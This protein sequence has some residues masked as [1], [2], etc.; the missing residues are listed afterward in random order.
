MYFAGVRPCCAPS[1][2]VIWRRTQG[3]L[4]SKWHQ[5]IIGDVFVGLC[6]HR[7]ARDTSPLLEQIIIVRLKSNSG[8]CYFPDLDWKKL[9]Q[10]CSQ[11]LAGFD[12]GIRLCGWCS[13][14]MGSVGYGLGSGG[15]KWGEDL[16]SRV[17]SDCGKISWWRLRRVAIISW[18]VIGV[19]HEIWRDVEAFLV[20]HIVSYVGHH[21]ISLAARPP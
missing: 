2:D 4:T 8:G 13:R 19:I 12:E 17:S 18:D 1:S 6:R 5:Q 11:T 21:W 10:A 14:S 3:T 20:T 7:L 15:K 16:S 9:C